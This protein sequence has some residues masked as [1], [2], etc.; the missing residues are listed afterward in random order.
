ME[1]LMTKEYIQEKIQEYRHFLEK[2]LVPDLDSVSGT[3][4]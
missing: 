4:T 2:V 1:P 3:G